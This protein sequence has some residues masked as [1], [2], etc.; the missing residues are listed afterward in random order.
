MSA[1][2][3]PTPVLSFAQR[4]PALYQGDPGLGWDSTRRYQIWWPS[5]CSVAALTAV[6]RAWGT[7]VGIGP[8]L[9]RLWTLH[10]ISAEQGLLHS[11]ALASVAGQYGYQAQLAWQW[12][13]PQVASI[14][15]QGVPVLVLLVDTHQQTPYPA[16]VIGHWLVV[17]SLSASLVEVRD[18]SGYHIHTLTPLLFHTLFTGVAVVVWRG[19]LSLP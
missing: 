9:D 6:S 8:A 14:A 18:S 3:T 5:A 12:S 10:A 15:A 11:E 17:V 19:T 2:P 7:H 16:F 13:A 1:W 4:V